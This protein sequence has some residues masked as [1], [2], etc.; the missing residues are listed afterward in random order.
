[1]RNLE[2][3]IKFQ[4]QHRN[5]GAQL[6]EFLL[7][8]SNSPAYLAGQLRAY[9]AAVEADL[10]AEQTWAGNLLEKVRQ[11]PGSSA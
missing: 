4:K 8:H 11:V 3:L 10:E 2:E 9:L 1:M 7:A 5:P 6:G